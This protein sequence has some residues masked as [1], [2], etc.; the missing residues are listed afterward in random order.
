M[1][2]KNDLHDALLE[3]VS[4][5]TKHNVYDNVTDY[6][7]WCKSTYGIH[8]WVVA[9][10]TKNNQG[11]EQLIVIIVIQINANSSDPSWRY[12]FNVP[13]E[14]PYSRYDEAMKIIG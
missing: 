14:D 1:I 13:P 12:E 2:S 3:T 11:M 10:S 9:T 5:S 7:I 4:L 8:D 6:L